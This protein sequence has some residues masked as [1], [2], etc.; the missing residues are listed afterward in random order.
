LHAYTPKTQKHI[1]LLFHVKL[2]NQYLQLLVGSTT[3]S[4]LKGTTI[5]LLHLGVI[6]I[7]SHIEQTPSPQSGT[8]LWVLDSIA[9]FHMTSDSSE[10][11]SLCPLE[12]PLNV[13]T[14]DG[15]SLSV[16]S[17]GT[18]YILSFCVLDVSLVPCLTLNLFP[19]LKLLIMVVT[20]SLMLILV[21]SRIVAPR[22]WLVLALGVVTAL[23]FWDLTWLCNPSANTSTTTSSH[24]LDTFPSASF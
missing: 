14:S 23:A 8:S 21:L 17:R 16:A 20:L 24:A 4:I 19:L 13:L 1:L 6:T 9:A 2:A 7:V 3:F 15:T 22:L 11:S 12:F 18:L 5:D 10:L